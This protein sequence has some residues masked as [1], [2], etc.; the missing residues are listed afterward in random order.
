MDSPATPE[1]IRS[2]WEARWGTP[3]VSLDRIY[4]VEDVEGIVRKGASGEIL[5]LVTWARHGEEG[6]IV[7]LDAL[8]EGKG[9]GTALL[10]AA[11]RILRDHGVK[12]IR[13]ITTDARDFYLRRGYREVRLHR[14]AMDRVRRIKPDVPA[15]VRDLWELEKPL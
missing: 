7:T 14:D 12:R 8:E 11:E 5:A 6:E 4:Q 2:V 13:V 3:I 1:I 10:Q 15:D 9:H